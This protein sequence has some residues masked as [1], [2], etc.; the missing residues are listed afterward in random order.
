MKKTNK[1]AT[2]VIIYDSY[3]AFVLADGTLQGPCSLVRSTYH[4]VRTTGEI[5]RIAYAHHADDLVSYG[6][7]LAIV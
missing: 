3:P 2:T 6:L 7:K 4:N 1:K 5:Q